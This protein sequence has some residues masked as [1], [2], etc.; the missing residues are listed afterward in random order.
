M[1]GHSGGGTERNENE[2]NLYRVDILVRRSKWVAAENTD[3]ALR[4]ALSE[5]GEPT[6]DIDSAE[7]S[8]LLSDEPE[9]N[10]YENDVFKAASGGRNE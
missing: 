4:D 1:S 7:V 5:L 9:S 8:E 2:D 6:G 3:E 10:F